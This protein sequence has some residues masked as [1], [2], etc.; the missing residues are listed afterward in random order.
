MRQEHHFFVALCIDIIFKRL[1]ALLGRYSPILI[2]HQHVV[3]VAEL[4]FE[5]VCKRSVYDESAVAYVHHVAVFVSGKIVCG[6]DVRIVAVAVVVESKLP[7][8]RVFR[9]RYGV[10]RKHQRVRNLLLRK[11]CKD[12]LKRQFP[13]QE[14]VHVYFAFYRLPLCNARLLVVKS[15]RKQSG[16]V[17][18]GFVVLVVFFS[19]RRQCNERRNQ[20]HRHDKQSNRFF[21][22]HILPLSFKKRLHR[23]VL[24]G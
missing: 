12:L 2:E 7:K 3:F 16:D 17:N 5:I 4:S 8:Q 11:A 1:C 9:I 22:F 21:C 6:H 23:K 15:A 24:S 10:E 19:A 13:F 20:K 14:S 18:D